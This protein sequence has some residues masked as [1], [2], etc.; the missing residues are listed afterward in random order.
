MAA[1]VSDR[2]EEDSREP[3]GGNRG[4]REPLMGR[5]S[6]I[7]QVTLRLIAQY[8]L[9]GASMSRIAQSVGISSAALYRHFQ[10][11][12]DI[13]ITAHV[14]LTDRVFAW[15]GSSKAVD[16]VQR[17][18]ELGERHAS[19]TSADIEL[20][21]APMFQFISWIPRDGLREEV[22]R[23]RLQL[24]QWFIDL[25]EE[26]KAQGSIRN[27]VETN[28]AVG[29]FIAWI[30]WEDLSYLEGLDMEVASRVSAEMFERFID[31][32]RTLD[33]QVASGS[34]GQVASAGQSL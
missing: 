4:G 3:S 5:K 1:S 34:T 12:E 26:G 14:S 11:R 13:L 23:G 33:P 30:W 28:V 9:A 32:I 8:G 20:F 18:R 29:Q 15:L 25:I 2:H 10:S 17:L 27:D 16:V 6:Q 7:V 19:S 24:R 21:N 31:G 22:T